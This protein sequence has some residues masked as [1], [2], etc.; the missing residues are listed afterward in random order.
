MKAKL[1]ID[2]K[3]KFKQDVFTNLIKEDIEKH[4]KPMHSINSAYIGIEWA[5]NHSDD[6]KKLIKN[7]DYDKGFQDAI[8]KAKQIII[9]FIPLPSNK[10]HN[11]NQDIDL[12]EERQ[13]YA[14]QVAKKFEEIMLNK[15]RILDTNLIE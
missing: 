15:E 13:K 12:L 8:E 3:R 2:I 9:S 1:K 5:L 6:I 10:N 7:N 11:I 4:G 14:H